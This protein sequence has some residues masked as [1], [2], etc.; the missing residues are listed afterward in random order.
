VLI[1]QALKLYCTGMKEEVIIAVHCVYCVYCTLAGGAEP[2]RSGS[3][4]HSEGGGPHR[5]G[6]GA[7]TDGAHSAVDC[8]D[9]DNLEQG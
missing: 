9:S 2:L 4:N 6:A 5:N 7:E 3:I 8:Q 1:A